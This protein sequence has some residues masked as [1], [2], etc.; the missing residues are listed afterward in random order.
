M[1]AADHSRQTNALSAK[2]TSR[3]RRSPGSKARRC[4]RRRV[5]IDAEKPPVRQ[6][7]NRQELLEA[8]GTPAEEGGFLNPVASGDNIVVGLPAV[9]SLLRDSTSRS[10]RESYMIWDCRRGSAKR[11]IN[12]RLKCIAICE[13]RGKAKGW[14]L[15][16]RCPDHS[17]I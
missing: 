3:R 12:L 1:R 11:K 2:S 17:S 6:T 13:N 9:G 10:E 5:A 14:R 8:L 4:V 16:Q 15:I 7:W